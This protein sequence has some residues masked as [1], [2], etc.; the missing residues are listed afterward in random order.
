MLL[1]LLEECKGE[2]CDGGEVGCWWPSR[3][4]EGEG[5]A[6]AVL[7]TRHL[8]ARSLCLS[9]VDEKTFEEFGFCGEVPSCFDG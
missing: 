2:F 7:W 1:S 8:T 5:L 9:M 4:F 6:F 3:S